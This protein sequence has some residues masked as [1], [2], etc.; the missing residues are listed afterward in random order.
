[1]IVRSRIKPFVI[2]GLTVLILAVVSYFLG[3]RSSFRRLEKDAQD[4]LL[5]AEKYDQLMTLIGN[6]KSYCLEFLSKT[7]GNFSE[8][9][10]C[11]KFVE[12]TKS[13]LE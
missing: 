1:M 4:N 13:L 3:M 11:Q 7:E 12:W 10:F 8:R 5:K 6:K 2:F 9:D